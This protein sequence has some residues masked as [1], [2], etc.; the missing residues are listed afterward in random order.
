MA[1]HIRIPKGQ[2][3]YI[4][5]LSV[6]PDVRSV[7]GKTQFKKSLKTSHK[8]TAQKLA[9]QIIPLWQA[10]IDQARQS[11]TTKVNNNLTQ[12]QALLQELRRDIAA[13][14]DPN[15]ATNLFHAQTAIEDEVAAI[16]GVDPQT[17]SDSA[18]LAYKTAVGQLTPFLTN[19]EAHMASNG[20]SD[21]AKAEKRKAFTDFDAYTASKP[22]EHLSKQHVLGF[23]DHLVGL[24]KA[25]ATV[26]KALSALRVYWDA[27]WPERANIFDK[28]SVASK[29]V[30]KVDQRQPFELSELRD[31]RAALVDY[32]YQPLL[33]TF[34]IAC[35]TGMR[36]EEI[37]Q[38]RC[39]HVKDNTLQ[40]VSAKTT[41]GERVV[42][43]A[44][45]LMP[46]I[47][48]ACEE[49]VDG[50]LVSID[51]QHKYGIRSAQLSKRFGRVKTQLGFGPTKVF[52]SIRKTVATVFE[53]TGVAEAVAADILGHEKHT[54]TYGLYSGGSSTDQKRAAIALLAVELD[55]GL[56]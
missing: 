56:S 21:K 39:E 52:H 20:A 44:A 6:P 46:Q 49:S 40:I 45:S 10:E 36:I 27:S 53:R 48:R 1:S 41:A 16:L 28:V 17:A 29:R 9:N 51:H 35:Y 22:V 7:V 42:P 14:T 19:V 26:R 37:C 4:A 18:I 43:I 47:V 23:R 30:R 55:R 12:L 32:G 8:P 2:S 24:G 11:S 34:D 5:L 50:Y 54:M 31:I 25:P 13:A 15:E 38:L 3:N 33:L